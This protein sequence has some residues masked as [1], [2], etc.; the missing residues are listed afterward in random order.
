MKKWV[1]IS[2]LGIAVCVAVFSI[3][4]QILYPVKYKNQIYA[5]AQVHGVQPQLIASVIRAESNFKHNAVSS[6]GA[7]GLMQIMPQTAEFVA[8]EIGITAFT[9]DMLLKPEINIHIGSWYLRYLLNKF[10]DTNTALYAYNAGEGNVSK[11]LK[12]PEYAKIDTTSVLTKTPFKES[13]AYVEKVNAALGFYAKK[14]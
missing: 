6:K 12:N 8:R 4:G 5:A 7:V 3:I 9:H 10:K 13:N 11:W 14:F 2:F 1:L